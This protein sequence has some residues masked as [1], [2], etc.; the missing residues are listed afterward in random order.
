MGGLSGKKLI[1]YI[2]AV[3]CADLHRTI[4]GDWAKWLAR[5][6]GRMILPLFLTSLVCH[7]ACFCFSLGCC[8]GLI[9]LQFCFLIFEDARARWLCLQNWVFLFFTLDLDFN[10]PRALVRF[11]RLE[12]LVK[13][14]WVSLHLCFFAGRLAAASRMTFFNQPCTLHVLILSCL[15][16]CWFPM[17]SH[18]LG[19]SVFGHCFLLQCDICCQPWVTVEPCPAL[20]LCWHNSLDRLEY[21]F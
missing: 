20:G 1:S 19:C 4:K 17:C 18:F 14:H 2:W 12:G 10:P 11:L 16:L 7:P 15:S 21:D 6:L 9:I 3:S 5:W 8:V 13:F